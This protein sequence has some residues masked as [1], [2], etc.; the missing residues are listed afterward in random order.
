MLC[1]S[2]LDALGMVSPRGCLMFSV[3]R[4]R[5]SNG[6]VERTGGEARR[7]VYQALQGEAP[8]DARESTSTTRNGVDFHNAVDAW[9]VRRF[10]LSDKRS[11]D[12]VSVGRD[13]VIGPDS[14]TVQEVH[15][16]VPSHRKLT[17]MGGDSRAAPIDQ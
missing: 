15:R 1:G 16:N 14:R 13:E 17:K 3:R 5:G 9:C 7:Q 4:T 6:P 8:C 11:N 2:I 10:T 12:A